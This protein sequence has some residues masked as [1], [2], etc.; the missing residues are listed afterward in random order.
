MT[1][2]REI[3]RSS[4]DAPQGFVPVLTVFAG[5]VAVA[6]VAGIG[7]FGSGDDSTKP[8]AKKAVV[9]RGSVADQG[10]TTMVP[11][12][13]LIRGTTTTALFVTTTT[14]ITTTTTTTTTTLPGPPLSSSESEVVFGPGQTS[15]TFVI[16]SADPEGIAFQITGVPTG[17]EVDPS[18]GVVSESESV[19][20]TVRLVSASS[21]RGGTLT[22]RGDDGSR[23]TVRIRLQSDEEG[24]A[25]SSVQFA[26]SPPLCRSSNRIVA[27]VTGGQT[28]GASARVEVDGAAS[29]I[30]LTRLGSDA[31]TGVLPE[32]PAGA[33]VSG[34]V[35]VRGPGGTSASGEFSSTFAQGPG[36]DDD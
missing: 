17:F 30:S 13:A 20:V 21:A 24:L 32:G 11:S 15:V 26:P 1:D 27:A 9:G 6:V 22:I 16:H 23:A 8:S 2:R 29:T 33:S 7:F 25:V 14:P 18:E 3:R 35:T 36:C 34:T 5:L 4:P 19:T 12:T 28:T 31:W 10:P